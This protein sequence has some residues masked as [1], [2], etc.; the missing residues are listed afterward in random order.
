MNSGLPFS[1]LPC[2]LNVTM[3]P[4]ELSLSG[5]PLPSRSRSLVTAN[6]GLANCD[7]ELV[8]KPPSSRWLSSPTTAPPPAEQPKPTSASGAPR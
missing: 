5:S 8:K 1:S 3:S 2:A 4:G 6:P 7:G